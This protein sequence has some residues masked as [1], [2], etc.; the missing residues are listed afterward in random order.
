MLTRTL[1]PLRL[2]TCQQ[3]GHRPSPGLVF[4]IDIRQLL[5]V[6]IAHHEAGVLFFDRPRWWEAALIHTVIAET[7]CNN[8]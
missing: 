4:K 2:I 5:P 1:S 7:T 6:V 8:N 3:L